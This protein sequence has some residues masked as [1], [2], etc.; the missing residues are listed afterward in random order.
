MR[1]WWERWEDVVAAAEREVVVVAVGGE[2]EAGVLVGFGGVVEVW[3]C[4]EGGEVDVVV[5]EVVMARAAE[6]V[7][8]DVATEVDVLTEG[9]AAVVE[10]FVR[11]E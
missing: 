10:V 5:A 1:W 11:A 8:W 4:V 6:A 9:G 3:A 7:N 2:G